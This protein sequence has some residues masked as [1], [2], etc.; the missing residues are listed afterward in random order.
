MNVISHLSCVE[1]ALGLG[2]KELVIEGDNTTFMCNITDFG[3]F[4]S[5]LV[6]N[7]LDIH[8]SQV[9]LSSFSV[10]FIHREGN[11]V[12]HSSTRFARHIYDDVI[13]INDSPPP[14]LKS[15]YFDLAHI[16]S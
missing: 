13:W 9:G 14:A 15:L 6:H 1:F 7:F 12:A 11:Y 10:S 16:A 4:S 2:F 3:P 8:S 5:C